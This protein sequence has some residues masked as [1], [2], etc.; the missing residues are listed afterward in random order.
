MRTL[1]ADDSATVRQKLIQLLEAIDSLEII[2]ET[3]DVPESI[4]AIR[5][6][7][8]DVVILDINMPGGSGIDV[9][10]DVKK[11]NHPPIV[12]MFTSHSSEQMRERCFQ[13]GADYFFHKSTEFDELV[14]VLR[15]LAGCSAPA[16]SRNGGKQKKPAIIEGRP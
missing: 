2:G 1:I 4:E 14:D 15:G 9:L 12:I 11:Q 13:A 8:P 10:E 3:E 16:R 6:L 5:D 7:R